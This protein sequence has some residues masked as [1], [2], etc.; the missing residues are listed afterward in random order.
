MS[1]SLKKRDYHSYP[2]SIWE[3]IWFMTQAAGVVLLMTLFF[4]QSLWAVLPLSGIGFWYYKRLCREKAYQCREELGTQ[5]RECLLAVS[6]ALQAG[7]AVENAFVESR[8]EMQSLYGKESLIYQELEFIRRGLVINI[9]LEELLNDLAGRSEVE[10][11]LQFA[12]IFS[13]AKK[14]GGDLPRIIRTTANLSV[15][16]AETKQEVEVLLSGKTME[17]N[18]MRLMPFGILAYIGLS[19]PGYFSPLYHSLQ[20]VI[21]MTLCLAV[22]SGAFLLGD[23]ILN[24][25]RARLSGKN[26]HR[27]P[28]CP[29]ECTGGVM[30][31]PDKIFRRLYQKMFGR[32]KVFQNDT[33]RRNLSGLYPGKDREKLWENYYVKKLSLC[34]LVGMAGAFL[35]VILRIKAQTAGEEQDALILFLLFETVAVGLFFLSDRDVK[36]E[37]T[38]RR[39]MWKYQYPDMIHKLVLYLGAGLSIRSAFARL[40]DSYETALYA[41]R[42]T[43]AGV[44]ESVAYEHFG[45]RTGLQSYVKL[46]ALLN[47]NLKRGTGTLFLRLEEEALQSSQ[48]RIQNGKKLGEEAGTKLL[49]PMVLMLGVVMLMIMIPAFTGL[50]I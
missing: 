2:L 8:E 16:R 38:H 40:S 32:W 47:Q 10:E 22:Y 45:K 3:K 27:T 21:I 37:M 49:I 29:E 42:E 50:G 13:I 5:F 31:I 43:E 41:Y 36:E 14:S 24:Q 20:G 17:L 7:Y 11:I 35:A 28:K 9:S 25:I 19:Y 23:C 1:E 39:N 46:A 4:Y 12:Q 34:S 26:V 33:V 18:V 48:E 30:G 15:Q 6:A 44:P